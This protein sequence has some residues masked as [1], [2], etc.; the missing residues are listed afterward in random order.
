MRLAALKPGLRTLSSKLSPAST[1]AAQATSEPAWRKW[2]HT[3]RWVRL[4]WEVLARDLF[5]CR[6]CGR[7][8]GD[9]SKLVADHIRPHRGRAELFWLASNLQTLCADPCHNTVKQR[10]EQATPPGV[11]D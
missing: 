3:K 7:T 2:Y 11:W 4:R 10:E 6:M 9:T 1:G 5:T 8:H